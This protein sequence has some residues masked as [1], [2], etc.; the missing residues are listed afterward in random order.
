MIRV[1]YFLSVSSVVAEKLIISPDA[2]PHPSHLLCDEMSHFCHPCES[3]VLWQ[4]DIWLPRRNPRLQLLISLYSRSGPGSV[5]LPLL[6]GP[7]QD[8]HI[9]RQKTHN[10]LTRAALRNIKTWWYGGEVTSHYMLMYR[11]DEM[12]HIHCNIMHRHLSF[13]SYTLT[14]TSPWQYF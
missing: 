1:I 14:T 3:S 12:Y 9:Q 8:K 10:N 5:A 11:Y 13:V 7:W 6:S 4:P 2:H